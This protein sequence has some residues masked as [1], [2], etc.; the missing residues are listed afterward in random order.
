M[1]FRPKRD[2][3]VEW[4]QHKG[5][6]TARK[7]G[8]HD[9]WTQARLVRRRFVMVEGLALVALGSNLAVGG[10]TPSQVVTEAMGE[11][12]RLGTGARPSRLWRSP[13]WPPGGPAYV[14]AAM[15]LHTPLSPEDL[16]AALHDIEAQWRRERT[17][18]W[19]P[20]TLDLDLLGW[21][22]AVRPD[23]ATQGAWRD[24]PPERQGREAPSGL[25]LPHPRMQDRG[26]VLGPLAE[27]APD[28]RHPLIARTV[29][30]MLAALPA[31]AL[32]GTEPL[33]P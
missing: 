28:W 33:A 7:E 27:V 11:V 25:V 22:D 4:R 2:G 24:L 23:A 14:N 10:Q 21:E 32:D 8:N 26:F 29:A 20:R 15:A 18:R 19:G 6:G 3:L 16:L 30:E 9:G 17:V 1:T 31:G 5:S 12:A 13:S